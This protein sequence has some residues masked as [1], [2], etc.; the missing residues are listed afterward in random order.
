[1]QPALLICFSWLFFFFLNISHL[2]FVPLW[3]ISSFFVF[4]LTF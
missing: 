3:R 1:M 4:S 2:N